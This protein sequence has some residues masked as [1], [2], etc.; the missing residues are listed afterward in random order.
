MNGKPIPK[1]K[2]KKSQAKLKKDL[3][4]VFSIYVRQKYADKEG[5]AQ[6][7][8]CEVT[9]EV[10]ELHCGHFISRS[11]LATRFEEDNVRPQCVGCN[12]FGGGR[13]V[14]FAANLERDCGKGTVDRLFKKAQ[15]IVKNFP[16]EEKIDYYKLKL[17]ELE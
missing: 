13:N 9:K 3:D 14:I 2:P 7:Y 8:T 10:R 17:K 6:C 5:K 15:E 16:Y 1:G 11:Y 4:K 12:V